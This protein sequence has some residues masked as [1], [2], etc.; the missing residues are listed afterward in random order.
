MVL[1]VSA[2]QTTISGNSKKKRADTHTRTHMCKHTGHG[3]HEDKRRNIKKNCVSYFTEYALNIIKFSVSCV[4]SVVDEIP[5]PIG[6]H[7]FGN[8]IIYLFDAIL[9]EIPNSFIL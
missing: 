6:Y 1:V 8:L 7:L 9:D 4:A 5:N 3:S 2:H